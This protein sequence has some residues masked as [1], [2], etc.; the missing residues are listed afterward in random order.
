MLERVV[1]GCDT[2]SHDY[3]LIHQRIEVGNFDWD[4]TAFDGRVTTTLVV[5]PAAGS[6]PS[7]STWAAQL[8]VRSVAGAS[9]SERAHVRPP[10]RLA[11]RAARRARPPA[12]TRCGSP[13]T[14]TGSITQGRG[15]YFF[16]EEPGRPHRPQQIYSGGGT[17]GNPRWIP[18]WGAP[19]DKATW[20]M[21]ATVPARLTVVSNGR[22]VSDRPARRRCD[23]SG[24]R[25]RRRSRRRPISSPSSW[26]R[27]SEV[28]DRWRDVPLD[29][30]VY[31]EDSA[32][33]RAAVRRHRRT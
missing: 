8:E 1:N 13:S 18:T 7:C 11:R 20:E 10:G 2:P 12:A 29:Y 33:A 22:L 26:R 30:Y 5:A 28:T 15:L 23:T 6:I 31:P 14:T 24:A 16:K 25:G 32:L 9:R 27:S 4:S 21:V 17:D 3:D 19:H